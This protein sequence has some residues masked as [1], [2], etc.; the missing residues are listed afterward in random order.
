MSSTRHRTD[1]LAIILRDLRRIGR[2]GPVKNLCR[3]LTKARGAFRLRT[4]E[5]ESWVEGEHHPDPGWLP[6]LAAILETEV[7]A[8]DKALAADMGAKKALRVAADGIEDS[9]NRLLFEH[10]ELLFRHQHAINADPRWRLIRLQGAYVSSH[11]GGM[12]Y[13]LPVLLGPLLT[14]WRDGEMIVVFDGREA[15]QT[16]HSRAA[17]GFFL[18]DGAP[19]RGG[20]RDDGI[21]QNVAY[22]KNVSEWSLEQLIHYLKDL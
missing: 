17:W 3:K 2:G 12:G 20:H 21:S 10:R 19:W 8:L 4:G 18:D 16:G 13:S 14:G 9:D 11:T 6:H 5:F 15:L 22:E 7:E 1:R